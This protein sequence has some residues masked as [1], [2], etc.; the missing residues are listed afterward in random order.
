PSTETAG[1]V[2][3]AVGA[4][5][6]ET[7]F[8]GTVAGASLPEPEQA[9]HTHTRPNKIFKRIPNPPNALAEVFDAFAAKIRRRY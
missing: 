3:C 5:F 7:V 1:A 8:V 4:M 2:A 6:A 9:V